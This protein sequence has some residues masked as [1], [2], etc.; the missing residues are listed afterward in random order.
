MLSSMTKDQ[1]TAAAVQSLQGGWEDGLT[2]QNVLDADVEYID[3]LICK[4][5]FHGKKAE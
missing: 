2:V 4:V 3:E 5:G 1:T